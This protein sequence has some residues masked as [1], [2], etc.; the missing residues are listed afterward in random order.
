MGQELRLL[1]I[2][3]FF[4]FS[5]LMSLRPVALL[6]HGVEAALASLDAST[7]GKGSRRRSKS[8]FER[9]RESH[10]LPS[11]FVSVAKMRSRWPHL[12][13]RRSSPPASIIVP[14]LPTYYSPSL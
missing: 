14:A 2:L 13:C 8:S 6:L 9:R 7:G 1:G 10:D 5:W 12:R 11:T 4:L 3:A